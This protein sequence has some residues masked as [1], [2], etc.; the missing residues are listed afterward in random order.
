ML[1]VQKYGGATLATPEKIKSVAQRIF[2]LKSSGQKVVAIVSA[3]G[4]TTNELIALAHQVSEEP[5]LR[6]LDMLLSV[7]ERT[8]MALV[9]MALHDLKCSAI[10]FTG[11]QA[12]I[13]TTESHINADIIDVKAFRVE[14]AL[15]ENKVVVL[16]GF[17]GVSRDAKEITTLGRGGSDTTAVAM[18]NY[19]KADRC[20]ILKDVEG[21]MT[22]DPQMVP[23][24][25]LIKTLSLEQLYQMTY[26]GAKVLHYKSAK[27][28]LDFNVPLYIGPAKDHFSEGTLI[29]PVVLTQEKK[30][31]GL[32]SHQFVFSIKTILPMDLFLS[33]FLDFFKQKQIAEPLILTSVA[34]ANSCTLHYLTLPEEGFLQLLKIKEWPTDYFMCKS[35]LSS[36]SL[37]FNHDQ[38]LNTLESN[39][40][41]LKT[42][43]VQVFEK[44]LT[45]YNQ[46]FFIERLYR[47]PALKKLHQVHLES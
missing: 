43:A 10:S 1:I 12:G 26:W 11:S 35:N 42:L 6:E 23:T 7:G 24:A 8:S 25:R 17:Q 45:K 40:N 5:S 13:I 14:Q 28:A 22:A 2:Q 41:N 44:S 32:N 9:T 38:H 20:E 36:I 37:T 4:K 15:N 18:A 3:M 47:E 19:L 46:N 21:V 39:I 30:C 33:S 34:E 16:A 31:L 29:Q 27:M